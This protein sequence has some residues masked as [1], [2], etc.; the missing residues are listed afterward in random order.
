VE[1]KADTIKAS[2]LKLFDSTE[3]PALSRQATN[4]STSS[5][6]TNTY[7]FDPELFTFN[8]QQSAPSFRSCTLATDLSE[9]SSEQTYSEGYR[10][11]HYRDIWR[12]LG[13]PPTHRAIEALRQMQVSGAV[14]YKGNMIFGL[15]PRLLEMLEL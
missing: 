3:S 10:S 12:G 1:E 9:R 8:S 2:I 11:V 14:S 13:C 6:P 4:T 5:S 15:H 7:G